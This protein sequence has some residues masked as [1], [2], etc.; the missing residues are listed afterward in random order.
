MWRVHT[1]EKTVMLG[2]IEGSGNRD[3]RGWFGWMASLTQWTWVWASSG[4]WRRTGKPGM[5]QSMGSQR[6]GHNLA[7]EQQLGSTWKTKLLQSLHCPSPVTSTQD[8][9][10]SITSE[11]MGSRGGEERYQFVL[12]LSAAISELM[13]TLFPLYL[14][15]SKRIGDTIKNNEHHK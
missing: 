10:Q 9:L 2:K 12:S 6:V 1:L 11:S 3:N 14:I 7:T 15:G 5:L 4:R 13:L 8:S